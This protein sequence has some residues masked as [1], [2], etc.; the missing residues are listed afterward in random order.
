MIKMTKMIFNISRVWVIVGEINFN[1]IKVKSCRKKSKGYLCKIKLR[2][3]FEKI[4]N[5]FLN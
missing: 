2:S 5:F 1:N 4:D 3:D